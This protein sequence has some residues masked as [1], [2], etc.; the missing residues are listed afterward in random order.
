MNIALIIKNSRMVYEVLLQR[1]RCTFDQ[2]QRLCHLAS[3][4]LCLALAHLIREKVVE[5]YCERQV[6]YYRL[7]A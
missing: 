1:T 3:T 7:P 6:V 2:L 4:D 5:Q